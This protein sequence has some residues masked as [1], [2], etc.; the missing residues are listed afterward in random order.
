MSFNAIL[1][2]HWLHNKISDH[3][4]KLEIRHIISIMNS[5]NLLDNPR[6]YSIHKY[7]LQHQSLGQVNRALYLLSQDNLLNPR[8]GW[9]NFNLIIRHEN[10][11]ALV[12]VIELLSSAR[13]LRGLSGQ[14]YLDTLARHVRPEEV[15]KALLFI[16]DNCVADAQWSK[17]SLMA[18]KP[19]EAVIALL[20]LHTSGLWTDTEFNR[21]QE[22]IIW[23]ENPLDFANALKFLMQSNLLD[24]DLSGPCFQCIAT[25]E[26]P[27]KMAQLLAILHHCNLLNDDQGKTNQALIARH[28]HLPSLVRALSNLETA[29]L[30]TDSQENLDL[31]V[32]HKNPGIIADLIIQ[33]T[34]KG[35]LTNSKAAAN[36][37]AIAKHS[38]P[39][40]LFNVFFTME[41]NKIFDDADAA[42]VHFETLIGHEN[43]EAMGLALLSL[44]DLGLLTSHLG[45][46]NGKMLARMT[47]PQTIIEAMQALVNSGLAT[48]VSIQKYFNAITEHSVPA[49][50]AST[51][52][53]LNQAGL[54][55]SPHGAQCVDA[56]LNSKKPIEVH[57]ALGHLYTASSFT[58]PMALFHFNA[59]IS[60][61]YPM[62]YSTALVSIALQVIDDT[63][64]GYFN[65]HYE[66]F[67]DEIKE[68]LEIIESNDLFHREHV[69]RIITHKKI[70]ELLTTLW[71]MNNANLLTGIFG[72]DNLRLILIHTY[73]Y[74]AAITLWLFD[75][76][77]VLNG[78]DTQANRWSIRRYSIH[79]M[80]LL[81]DALEELH[82][83]GLLTGTNTQANFNALLHHV[84]PWNVAMALIALHNE[85]LL[86]GIG[87]QR[88]RHIVSNHPDPLLMASALIQLNQA[89]L[90][91]GFEAHIN[92]DKLLKSPT[93]LAFVKALIEL[94][95]A[96][97]LNHEYRDIVFTHSNPTAASCALISFNRM[98]YAS[99]LDM[100]LFK[101]AILAHQ[102]PMAIFNAIDLLR[103]N[104]LLEG[105]NV[106]V[107]QRM[108]ITHAKPLHAAE[109]LVQLHDNHLFTDFNFWHY[110][111]IIACAQDPLVAAKIISVF[112]S[113]EKFSGT[114]AR[115]W[116]YI[117]PLLRHQTPLAIAFI[118]EAL[119]NTP[120]LTADLFPIN[121]ELLMHHKN[122]TFLIHIMEQLANT[123]LFSSSRAQI[124]FDLLIVHENLTAL[125]DAMS[126]LNEAALLTQDFG[127][128]N[129]ELLIRHQSPMLLARAFVVLERS[130]LLTNTSASLNCDMVKNHANPLATAQAL[131]ALNNAGLLQSALARNYHSRLMT[132]AA[133]H[134]IT[135]LLNGL[136]Q[137]H[138]ANGEHHE[139][140]YLIR[141]L[142][143][144]I[145]RI[146][147][148]PKNDS[149]EIKFGQGF[150]FFSKSRAENRKLNYQHAVYLLE[151]LIFSPQTISAL[152]PYIQE[153]NT[154]SSSLKSV[155]QKIEE[156]AEHELESNNIAPAA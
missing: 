76:F 99:S 65:R 28:N 75:Q 25:H 87:A 63:D 39:T 67:S 44:K 112:A 106:H 40:I 146:E 80:Q 102:N 149:E 119:I 36:R 7:L 35:L 130:G 121:F 127:L 70:E 72:H 47:K 9:L 10:I 32:G 51:I 144:Y 22:T 64:W 19:Y 116:M 97:L 139:R 71:C 147:S 34:R 3:P 85:G 2:P 33:L 129:L 108:V 27:Y 107:Y 122:V 125:S 26:S 16:K 105:I 74:K 98:N 152:Y 89:G 41:R 123:G 46:I 109:A 117:N 128:N 12:P 135:L 13:L 30:L 84:S 148:Y 110:L 18:L 1:L 5:A 14:E 136:S 42:Q 113:I 100:W 111:H 82:L 104:K 43:P 78:A 23:H 57:A 126:A 59:I 50:V 86:T 88:N 17:I 156:Q 73:P 60:H 54:L 62:E 90:L 142:K 143:K 95:E 101:S 133:P 91:T 81:T 137:E 49:I 6:L 118:L 96:D 138:D 153:L 31:T 53:T 24:P 124:V 8:S 61:E 154:H 103:N 155:F 120:L 131:E 115:L 48:S 77:G 140:V 141:I 4:F 52:L 55:T 29:G 20:P 114:E 92:R 69:S 132:H 150:V 83:R 11:N 151:E 58:P 134:T 66:N 56:V 37:R 45:L 21:I 38:A 93:P 145:E 68:A 94:N 79:Q 15:A